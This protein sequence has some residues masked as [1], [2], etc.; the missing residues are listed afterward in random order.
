[1]AIQWTENLATGI[2]TIDEQHK[3]LIVRVNS[4]LD[5]CQ[6]GKGKLVMTGLLNYCERQVI[7]CSFC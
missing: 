3:E 5:A 7:F 2:D 1:M 4:L 6:Q